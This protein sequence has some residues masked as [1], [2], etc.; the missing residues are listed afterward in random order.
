MVF[1]SI[2]LMI[3]SFQWLTT[4]YFKKCDRKITKDMENVP[5]INN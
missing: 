1:C 2:K 4:F 3:E 5:K